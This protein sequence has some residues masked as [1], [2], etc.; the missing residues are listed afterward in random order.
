MSTIAQQAPYSLAMRRVSPT[1]ESRMRLSRVA[2]D[3]YL[4]LIDF[5]RLTNGEA[6]A[7]LGVSAT[8]LGRM[9]RGHRPSLGQD[10]LTR[11]SALVAIFRG[12]RIRLACD[13]ADDWVLKP[14]GAPLFDRRTPLDAMIEGGIPTM[15]EV[16]RLVQDRFAGRARQ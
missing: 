4:S 16:R 10:Q 9:K 6:A 11:V 8:T 12:L 7:L 3:G 2:L 5:W 15:I 1:L 14:N 13:A